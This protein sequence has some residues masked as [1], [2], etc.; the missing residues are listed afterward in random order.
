[1]T[2]GKKVEGKNVQEEQAQGNWA[3]KQLS[4]GDVRQLW[5]G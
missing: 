5:S 2:L 4:E 3:K 1:M